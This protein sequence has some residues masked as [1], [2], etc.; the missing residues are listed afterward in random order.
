M[1]ISK[2]V[3][4][5]ALASLCLNL[6]AFSQSVSINLTNATVKRA[7]D[8]LKSKSGYSFVFSSMDVDTKKKVSL[9]VE[10]K[11]IDEAIKQ[12]LIGQNLTYEINGTN[13]IVK[14][15]AAPTQNQTKSQRQGKLVDEFGEAVIG[16]SILLKGTSTGTISDID[17]NFALEA[18]GQQELVI[19]MV[20]YKTLHLQ[21]Q[22]VNLKTP[23]V[24]MEDALM[25]NEVV[26]IGYGSVKKSD[27][28][29]SV[30]NVSS[31][32][33]MNQAKMNDPIQALQG[34]IAGADITSGNGPGSRSSIVI[35]GYNTLMRSGGDAP[36]IIVDD[37]PF[38]GA[39]DEINPAEIEKIDVLKDASSTAI[40]GARGANG[41]I[42]ITT[43]RA[44]KDTRLHIEYDGFYGMAKSF[45][46]FDVMDGPMYA[47]YRKEAYANNGSADAFDDVQK[48]VMESGN[49][50]DWQKVMFDDWSYKTNHSLSVSTSTGKNRNVVVLG[51]NKDQGIISNM[52]YERFTGR[53]TSDLE[54]AKNLTMGYS[55]S[56]ALA[57]RETGDA[58]VWRMGTRMDP[59]SEMYDEN[60]EMNVFTNKWMRDATMV[61][62]IFDTQRENVDVQNKRSNV[63]GNLYANWEI[64][65]GL[66][67]KSTFTYS[68]SSTEAG[69]YFGSKSNNRKL[70][71]NGANFNKSSNQ[72][73]NFTNL[74]TYN[75]TVKEIHRFDASFV[76][77]MQ[78]Y[79]SNAIGLAG[80]D[81]PY[82]GMWYNVNEAQTD[83]TIGSNKNEW[84]LLSFM[85]RLNYSLMDRY[86]FTL[87]GRYDGSS[88][89][90][91][92]NKWA[93]FPSAAVAWRLSEEPFMNNFEQLSNLKVRA[94]FGASGNTAID[95][96]AT[97]GQ[98]GR[99]PYNF[100]TKEVGAWGY[101][102]ALI[103]NPD[104]GWERTE[105][106]DLGIDFGFFNNRV[107]GTLDLYER[108]T[109]DLLMERKLP[110]T[111]G[112][113][114][115]WQNVG[116]IR[117]RGFEFSVQVVPIEQKDLRLSISA[118][119]SYNKNEIVKLFNGTEDSPAN[120]WFIGQPVNVDRIY[121]YVG[122]WQLDEAELAKQYKQVVGTT[123]LLD[124]D[125]N[126]LY[127]QND[128]TIYN[129]IPKW[130][131][132]LTV[133]AQFKQFDFSVYAYG[134]FDYG[135]RMG[136]L[137][138]DQGS[139]RF[140]QIGIRDFWTI[141][142]PTNEHPRPEM[143]SIGLLSGSS[144]AWRDLSFV[145]IKNIN[146]GY[147]IPTA[148]TKK[149]GCKGFRA[150]VA[151]D[152][153]F[154][155][156]S[157]AYEGIGLDPENCNSEAAARPLTSFM[158]GINAKF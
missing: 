45:T 43:K 149:F 82:Y 53:F 147:T 111:T 86:L 119:M 38:L 50:I 142:N 156:T 71:V 91:K 134:R 115:V 89:L 143:V 90:A 157:K 67:F 21:A 133:N 31:K 3:I 107:S 79:E 47:A 16:A 108:N 26:A 98:Y 54:L 30:A 34:Q 96:Y 64:V 51:Y 68:F 141:D 22:K 112:Y 52:T 14:K 151:V 100:G 104:L 124:K 120:N 99:Y 49:Y 139:T 102:P 81:I 73:V 35:R 131:G 77:D 60:G 155:F 140:N 138:Y 132:G 109:Y 127:D 9:A 97:Q 121:E 114:S 19:S 5:M 137:T 69:A 66:N 136:T 128:L 55:L 94:S 56:V 61:N 10:D 106:L 59:I 144:W 20:G 24:L 15:G 130:L 117:N 42:I 75:K 29:G 57:N 125:E 46:N 83:V 37:A 2:K 44:Q 12:I 23:I 70:S 80:F 78:T 154:L 122:V 158:F 129:R 36:L 116:Q 150:Y 39:I 105:E 92:G 113:P 88:R 63:S 1:V 18:T 135:T 95:T 6:T 4:C 11:D 76:H 25:L 13:I 93:F 110:T 74:L 145:R 33:I 8:E 103:A 101:V 126:F 152:N 7:M 40:Y 17:G 84:A 27:L 28:T 123:K 72:Q 148:V 153:P 62:P 65:K 146:L 32:V 41:V 87:T 85:T 58:N 48:R 118:N